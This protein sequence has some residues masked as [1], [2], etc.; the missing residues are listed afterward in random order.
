MALGLLVLSQS[1]VLSQDFSAFYQAD[2]VGVFPASF[3]PQT[4]VE[5]I[6]HGV[7]IGILPLAALGLIAGF[8]TRVSNLVC[9]AGLIV[10]QQANPHILQGGDVLLRL[11]LFWSLF[12]PL[13]QVWSLDVQYNRIS[14]LLPLTT[15][16]ASWALT[17]QICFVYWFA[18]LLKSDPLWTQNGN[19]LFYAL[20]IEH[21]TT[22]FGLYLRQYPDFLRVLTFAT[23]GLEVFGPCL[24]FIPLR[25]EDFRLAAVVLF[26][27]FHLVGMQ[28]LLRIGLFPWVCA[29]AWLVFLPR[30]FW[31][32]LL[33]RYRRL[34]QI[35]TEKIKGRNTIQ[36][37]GQNAPVLPTC[38]YACSILIVLSLADV[39][40]WNITSVIGDGARREMQ[41][42]DAFGNVLRL[43][44]QWNMYAPY[45][46]NEHGWL[47]V[48]ADLANGTQV[49]LFT[50][51][52][53]SWDKPQDIGASFRNDRWRRYL[54]NLFDDQ[55]PQTLHGYA[56]YL[57]RNWNQCH[58]ALQQVQAVTIIFMK[59][60][61]LPI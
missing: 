13:S 54:S 50:G 22:P 38:D 12:L 36:K 30:S 27:G 28:S 57:V 47:V 53:V 61:T 4:V 40:A 52:S 24:L 11:L 43:E 18:V 41:Q 60:V 8:L 25:R 46:R 17:L 42:H 32:W 29:T 10:V 33:I 23:L 15:G 56:D 48:P 5:S 6:V 9:F 44:Q 45:P 31:D 7:L 39:L 20:N 2:G 55:N 59:Q 1:I 37:K 21:F 19:A 34:A 49:D 51:Q 16:L 14:A 35:K 58:G 26:V 3:F